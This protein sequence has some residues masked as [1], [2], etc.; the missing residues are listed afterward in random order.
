MK[1]FDIPRVKFDVTIKLN[2][3]QNLNQFTN[4]ENIQ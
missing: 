2:M 3:A 4:L 1:R